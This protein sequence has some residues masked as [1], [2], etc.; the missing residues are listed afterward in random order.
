MP[1]PV[2]A[3]ADTVRLVNVHPDRWVMKM[4]LVADVYGPTCSLPSMVRSRQW[5][6]VSGASD[7]N[8]AAMALMRPAG[9][10]TV[11]PPSPAR[12]TKLGGRNALVRR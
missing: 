11:P 3:V 7:V 2:A 6:A 8:T 10:S 1:I 4:P 5:N 12:V 9:A